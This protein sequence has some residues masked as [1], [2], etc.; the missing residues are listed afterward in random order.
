[1]IHPQDT[2][3]VAQTNLKENSERLVVISLHP[4]LDSINIAAMKL[5]ENKP[6]DSLPKSE[7]T[8]CRNSTSEFG[9]GLAPNQKSEKSEQKT[10]VNLQIHVNPQN[11]VNGLGSSLPNLLATQLKQEA[12]QINQQNLADLQ[13]LVT[14]LKT[15]DQVNPLLSIN[16]TN[17]QER[18]SQVRSHQN[19]RHPDDQHSN[20]SPASSAEISQPN[21]P[22]SDANEECTNDKLSY[23]K[24]CQVKFE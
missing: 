11:S 5:E 6:M 22:M 15:K 17:Q 9:S 18:R 12:D 13:S 14:E 10:E 19:V 4:K 2:T 24:I 1:M 7:S 21:S 23:C 16:P 20:I 8:Q 3:N